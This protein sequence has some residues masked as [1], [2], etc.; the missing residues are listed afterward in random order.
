MTAT[1]RLRQLLDERGVEW[2]GE[3]ANS[4]FHDGKYLYTY[5]GKG[6]HCFT[7][8]IG[9]KEG[10]LG[11]VTEFS[12]SGF[13]PEQAV[14]ATLRPAVP[15]PEPP[16]VPYD[17]LIDELR[18]TWGIEAS[19]D[20]LRKFW[21][22]GWTEEYV[23]DMGRLH[24]ELCDAVAEG[25]TVKAHRILDRARFA[26]RGKCKWE[27]ADFITEGEWWKTSCGESFTWEPDGTPRFCPNCGRRVE[28]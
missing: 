20:G 9:A 15:P 12:A 28:S 10:T 17:I 13:T 14:A 16:D 19:W 8:P 6:M 2:W 11:A 22:L 4:V 25:N 3:E 23:E 24:D 1:E 21:Y 27:P 18:D 5:W 26:G 7:E